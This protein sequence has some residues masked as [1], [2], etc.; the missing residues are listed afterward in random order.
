MVIHI[1]SVTV[2]IASGRVKAKG[3][4]LPLYR[5]KNGIKDFG[6]CFVVSDLMKPFWLYIHG[7]TA[8]AQ[9]VSS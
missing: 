7:A 2:G 3:L 1:E 8:A 9:T 4:K 6:S 5:K